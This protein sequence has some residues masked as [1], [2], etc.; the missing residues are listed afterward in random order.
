M[1]HQ[2]HESYKLPLKNL[3]DWETTRQGKLL[4]PQKLKKK[5]CPKIKKH[6]F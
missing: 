2:K 1:L 4:Q 6:D 3:V 5:K